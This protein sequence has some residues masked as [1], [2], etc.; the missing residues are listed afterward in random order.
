MNH[1]S[2]IWRGDTDVRLAEACSNACWYRLPWDSKART[3]CQTEVISRKVS[4]VL[5]MPWGW[6]TVLPDLWI[7]VSTSLS[8][9]LQWPRKPKRSSSS[10]VMNRLWN[11]DFCNLVIQ[12]QDIQRL[13]DG[14]TLMEG[15]AW[16]CETTSDFLTI[17]I[18]S[19]FNTHFC[20]FNT[21]Q[22]LCL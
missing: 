2:G 16:H 21:L 7:S 3:M 9:R 19:A 10:V 11:K 12:A 14:L 1:L 20:L 13:F 6:P 5:G 4:A 22:S 18:S 17:N 8:Y 15:R